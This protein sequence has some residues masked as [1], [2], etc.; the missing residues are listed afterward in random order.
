MND[1][2]ISGQEGRLTYQIKVEVDFRS[3][4]SVYEQAEVFSLVSGLMADRVFTS[5]FYGLVSL[6]IK[7]NTESLFLKF[8]YL[9][10]EGEKEL[11]VLDEATRDLRGRR[12]IDLISYIYAKVD[13][14]FPI[15]DVPF[16]PNFRQKIILRDIMKKEIGE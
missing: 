15:I 6:E 13:E 12:R 1:F 2:E 8:S 7:P 16:L 14:L 5:I 11:A 9:D 4:L 10:R 3:K